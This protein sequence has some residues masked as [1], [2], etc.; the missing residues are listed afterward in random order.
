MAVKTA[1]TKKQATSIARKMELIEVLA[2][3]TAGV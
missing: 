2:Q 1:L 3:H